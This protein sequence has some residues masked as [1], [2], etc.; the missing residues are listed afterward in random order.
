MALF[1]LGRAYCE[2]MGGVVKKSPSDAFR[3]IDQAAK[4]GSSPAHDLLSAM[5]MIGKGIKIDE[6]KGTYHNMTIAYGLG[7]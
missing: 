6:T 2:G 1:M 7:I 3:L 4:L 5:Y